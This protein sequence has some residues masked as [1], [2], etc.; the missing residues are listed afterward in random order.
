MLLVQG[1][2]KETNYIVCND[3]YGSMISNPDKC[4]DNIDEIV[5]ALKHLGEDV[6]SITAHDRLLELC[7]TLRH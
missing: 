4:K 6:E 1:T 3:I 5:S 7:N 2:N